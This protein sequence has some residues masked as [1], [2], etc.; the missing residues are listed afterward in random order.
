MSFNTFS[1]ELHDL[2]MPIIDIVTQ[3]G[4]DRW[5]TSFSSGFRNRALTARYAVHPDGAVRTCAPDRPVDRRPAVAETRPSLSL[6]VDMVSLSD[7]PDDPG[8]TPGGRIEAAPAGPRTRTSFSL[9]LEHALTK[10]H[11]SRVEVVRNGT[12]IDNLG[13]GGASLW[14][15]AYDTDQTGYTLRVSDSGSVGKRVFNEVRLQ[16]VWNDER[17]ESASRSAGHHCA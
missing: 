16:S 8:S 6:T 1:A 2:G 11:T 17:A 13:V 5:R 4:L 12:A 15:R 7:A 14:E 3:P 9:E 10:T